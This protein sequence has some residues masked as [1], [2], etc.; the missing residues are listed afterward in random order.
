MGGWV[1]GLVGWLVGWL[2]LGLW[3]LLLLLLLWSSSSWFGEGCKFDVGVVIVSC[4][5]D[6]ENNALNRSGRNMDCSGAGARSFNHRTSKVSLGVIHKQ[7]QGF[8]RLFQFF[9]A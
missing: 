5:S 2:G 4:V 7:G 8:K 1:G 3:L 6:S 9:Q